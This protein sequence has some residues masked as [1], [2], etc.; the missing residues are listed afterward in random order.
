VSSCP[1]GLG[2]HVAGLISSALKRVSKSNS[3][4]NSR[5]A[6]CI[7]NFPIDRRRSETSRPCDNVGGRELIC[8]YSTTMS[9]R[10][11]HLLIL[12]DTDD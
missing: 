9:R 6:V 5:S 2:L 8:M 7:F 4:L 12:S 1:F 10:R 11:I 3:G